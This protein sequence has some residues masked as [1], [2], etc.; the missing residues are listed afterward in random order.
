[1][2][3]NSGQH[4]E[5]HAKLFEKLRLGAAR[6]QSGVSEANAKI[7]ADGAAKGIDS[8]NNAIVS[9]ANGFAQAAGAAANA[10]S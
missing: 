4:S 9:I 7:R 1:M 2:K 6:T 5:T 8:R 10:Q 3:T